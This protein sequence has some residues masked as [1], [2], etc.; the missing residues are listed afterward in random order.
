SLKDPFEGMS[1]GEHGTGG[2]ALEGSSM[3]RKEAAAREEAK[4]APSAPPPEQITPA[5]D[6][7][8]SALTG[9]L[10]AALAL[11]VVIAAALNDEA[12]ASRLGLG[13]TS[14][15]VATRVVSGLYDTATG[16]P[17]FF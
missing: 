10:G 14:E 11:A 4:E 16:K 2:T 17:V 15:L 7:V 8:S 5:R 3:A 12:A 13:F 9:L 1:L 6:M